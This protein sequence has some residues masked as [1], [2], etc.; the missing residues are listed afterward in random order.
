MSNKEELLKKY[1]ISSRVNAK[2][3]YIFINTL[4]LTKKEVLSKI[5]EQNFAKIKNALNS[6]Q[7]E[8]VN[9]KNYE[10]NIDFKNV[11]NSLKANEFIKDEHVK[12]MY[13]FSADSILNKKFNLFKEGLLFNSKKSLIGCPKVLYDL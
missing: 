6:T 11:I 5:K 7:R 8:E 10:N 1:E 9:S 3:K 13:I 12:N 2:P 4:V